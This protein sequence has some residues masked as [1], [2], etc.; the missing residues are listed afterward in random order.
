MPHQSVYQQDSYINTYLHMA[1]YK[2]CATTLLAQLCLAFRMA[3]SANLL[4]IVVVLLQSFSFSLQQVCVVPD[5]G[6]S[7]SCMTVTSLNHFCKEDARGLPDHTLVILL[8]GT[9]HLNTSCRFSNVSN[10]TLSSETGSNA[11]I[12]CN[13]NE[14]AGFL[15]L[16]VSN[17]VMSSF[18][19]R[20]C[21]VAWDGAPKTLPIR[22][23]SLHVIEGRDYLLR[24]VSIVSGNGGIFIYNAGGTVAINSVEVTHTHFFGIA[25]WY[26]VYLTGNNRMIITDSLIAFQDGL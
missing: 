19:M 14:N 18:E 11:T 24:N 2:R 12:Q 25:A 22:N 1:L 8:S 16:N 7:K 26:D 21:A 3:T 23:A 15:F 10:I 6:S 9:H 5:N 17:L 20:Q 13:G 4:L